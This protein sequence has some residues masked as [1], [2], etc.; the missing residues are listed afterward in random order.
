M[1]KSKLIEIYETTVQKWRLNKGIG[2]VLLPSPL[3]AHEV[4]LLVLQ[5]MYERSPTLSIMIV[6]KDFKARNEL[7]YSLTHTEDNE[8][9]EEFRQLID[10]KTLRV[11]THDFLTRWEFRDK[12]EL[13]IFININDYTVNMEKVFE[14]S[15]YKLVI[16][17]KLIEDNKRRSILYAKVPLINTFKDSE[18]MAINLNSPVEETR[19]AVTITNENELNQLERYNEYIAQ[20]VSIFGDFNNMTFARIGNTQLNISGA[21]IREEIAKENGWS[22]NLDMSIEINRQIDSIF[23]P[24]ILLERSELTFDIM[25]KRSQ[26]LTDNEA[27]LEKL[28]SICL[29]NKDKRIL[30]VNKRAEFAA[31]VTEF[32]N[33]NIPNTGKTEIEGDIFDTD[34]PV[35]RTY[36]LCANYHDKVDKAP[37]YDK[38]GKPIL[39]K[40]GMNK[41]QQ[42]MMAAKAQNSE[43]ERLFNEGYITI[44]STNN[45]P[46]K[47]LKCV[48]DLLIITS[49]ICDTIKELKYRL[50]G[51][52][53]NSLP[54]KVIKLYCRNTLEERSLSKEPQNEYHQIVNNSEINTVYDENSGVMIV[55]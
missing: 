18:L 19:I 26:L 20:S 7:I 21:T 33:N 17:N 49:P 1:S 12:F 34:K 27:K 32:L 24:N 37:A 47:G 11:Y 44:L 23:N 28:L 2:T 54:N 36:P 45:S 41:G 50:S 38:Y 9:N 13:C 55:D 48:I 3:N 40:S 10:A 39:I 30:I 42:K 15:H 29:E 35:F 53:F 51:V 43:N 22:S 25:R 52:Q 31:K 4:V 46:D 5:K 8:N 6:V 14:L 16:L